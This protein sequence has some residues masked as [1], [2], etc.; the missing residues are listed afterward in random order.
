MKEVNKM[1][2][3]ETQLYQINLKQRD[4][5]TA[6][7]RLCFNLLVDVQYHGVALQY[8]RLCDK[9]RNSVSKILV[10]TKVCYLLILATQAWMFCCSSCCIIF[11]KFT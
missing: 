8:E 4:T 2:R 3:F 6:L 10:L 9:G 11:F 7:D 5:A 1:Q